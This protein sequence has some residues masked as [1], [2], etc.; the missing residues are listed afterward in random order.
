MKTKN[1][2]SKIGFCKN[3]YLKG[4]K[5]DKE[6]GHYVYIRKVNKN[7]TCDVNTFTS[8]E[9]NGEFRM[10][11]IEHIKKG[12]IY[13]IPKN[14]GNFTVWTACT[15]HSIKNVKIENIKDIGNKKIK[16]RHLFFIGKYMK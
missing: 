4:V 8:L 9:K 2:K 6:K 11:K 5:G 10:S 7:G 13:P 16:Q 14:D 1:L 3:K 15:N 12:N